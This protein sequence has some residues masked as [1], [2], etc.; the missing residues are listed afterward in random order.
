M[1]RLIVFSNS[2]LEND[3]PS[4]RPLNPNA[5]KTILIITIFFPC[6]SPLEVAR[7]W[8]NKQHL[9]G[10]LDGSIYA[11]ILKSPRSTA[12]T[13]LAVV[14]TPNVILSPPPTELLRG[15]PSLNPYAKSSH[16]S[17]STQSLQIYP[18]SKYSSAHDLQ[19]LSPQSAVEFRSGS[20]TP[21]PFNESSRHVYSPSAAST[22]NDSVVHFQRAFSTPPQELG[23]D[24]SINQ[25]STAST[26]NQQ[27]HHRYQHLQQSPR[28]FVQEFRL[29]EEF[30]RPQPST[31]EG[32]RGGVLIKSG[33][34]I[35]KSGNGSGQVVDGGVPKLGGNAR[36]SS[37]TLSIDSGISSGG[38]QRQQVQSK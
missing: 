4:N 36:D 17:G 21:T 13:S 37:L 16:L 6:C 25:S 28:Q 3:S 29:G 22:D 35:G 14:A 18:T 1:I 30:E 24:R 31:G 9:H 19:Y 27:Q 38:H 15:V 33:G 5:T 2:I 10:P 34:Q 8:P 20:L 26:I 7:S 23:R 12:R 32:S 11:T